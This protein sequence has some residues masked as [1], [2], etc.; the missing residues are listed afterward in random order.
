MNPLAAFASFVLLPA[1]ALLFSGCLK[2]P[3]STDSCPANPEPLKEITLREIDAR[4]LAAAIEKHRGRAVLVDFW[5]TWC[6]P[7]AQ[8]FPHTVELHRR[9]SRDDLAVIAV[10]MDKLDDRT[11]VLEFLRR[12]GADT[13]N[14]QN[15]IESDSEAFDAYSIS[16]GLPHTCI[17]DRGGKLVRTIDGNRPAEIDQAVL[18]AIGGGQGSK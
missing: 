15:S 2:C 18:A 17:Y 10:S 14:Y 8:L 7:C 9:Y 6:G 16:E 12:R 13:E 11:A 5:A 3:S 1:F 4:G